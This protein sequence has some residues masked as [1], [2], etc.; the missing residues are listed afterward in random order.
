MREPAAFHQVSEARW[1]AAQSF[2]QRFAAES[3][4][5]GDDWNRWW[6]AAF[7]GH[8]VL[9]GQRFEDVLEVG[10]GPHTNMRLIL[11]HIRLGRLWLEDPLIDHYLHLRQTRRVLRLFCVQ[12]RPAVA[13][14]AERYR[15]E[16]LAEQLE[17]LPLPDRSID[18]CVCVNVLDHVQDVGLCLNQMRRVLKPNGILVIGQDL[19]NEEDFELCPESVTDIGHPIKVDASFLDSY[20]GDLLPL[21]RKILSREQGRNPNCHYGTYLLI[22]QQRADLAL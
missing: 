9:H 16:L 15:A 5:L 8:R 7:D 4:A 14:I 11:P 21:Y 22:G 1:R 13:K 18:L 17:E 6:Y 12:S 10:C 2:E 20:L 19:S 3:I